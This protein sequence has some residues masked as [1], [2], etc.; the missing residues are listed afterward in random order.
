MKR[1][2]ALFD[3]DGVILDSESRYTEFWNGIERIYPT[4]IEN[5]AVAIKGTTLPVILNNYASEDVRNDITNRL[6]NFQATMPFVPFDGAIDFLRRLHEAGI[7]MA[8]VTSSDS[9]KLKRLFATLPQLRE[10]FDTVI[11]GDMVKHSK[12]DPEG[13]LRAARS[14]GMDP[15]RCIVFEDSLQGLAAGRASGAKVVA[16]ATTY[17]ADRVRDLA[18]MT[19]PALSAIDIQSLNKLIES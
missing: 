7:P 19:A 15:E 9:L 3:L 13:Y 8:L 12:P 10:Q 11:D 1:F 4:G 18:D 5:Y 6:N 16:L 17:P 14:I 2:G